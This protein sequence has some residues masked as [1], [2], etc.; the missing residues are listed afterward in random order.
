[1]VRKRRHRKL[2]KNNPVNH[3]R[4]RRYYILGVKINPFSGTSWLPRGL[5][6]EESMRSPSR[7]CIDP[8]KQIL[9]KKNFEKKNFEKKKSKKSSKLEIF[10]MVKIQNIFRPMFL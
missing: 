1:M 7:R 9:I 10:T 2:K 6:I 3:G 5:G 8:L 4:P